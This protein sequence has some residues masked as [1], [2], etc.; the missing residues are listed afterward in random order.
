MTTRACETHTCAIVTSFCACK[1]HVRPHACGTLVHT[2]LEPSRPRN[3]VAALFSESARAMREHVFERC[4]AKAGRHT[5]QVYST[6]LWPSQDNGL[7]TAQKTPRVGPHADSAG[8]AFTVK[9]LES[10]RNCTAADQRLTDR[11]ASGA[12]SV[13][14]HISVR[15]YPTCPAVLGG[16]A[17]A[18]P[19][20]RRPRAVSQN[21]G[22]H[23][24]QLSSPLLCPS[25]DYG[26]GNAQKKRPEVVRMPTALVK[27]NCTAADQR[28]TARTASGG[29]ECAAAQ[30]GE[31]TPDLPRGPGRARHREGNIVLADLVE[32]AEDKRRNCADRKPPAKAARPCTEAG[33]RPP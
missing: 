21:A 10:V 31:T 30:L 7:G 15:R 29:S 20:A 16:P 23:A 2:K 17:S 25:Q 4:P 14:Q 8:Q 9:M 19:L 6:L 32:V 18:K 3:G 28:L 33:A 5:Q 13:R 1:M 24:Q 26:L 27:R 11:T 12:P 22:R